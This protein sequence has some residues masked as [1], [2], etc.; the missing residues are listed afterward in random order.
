[1]KSL[2]SMNFIYF[3]VYSPSSWEMQSHTLSWR[4]MDLYSSAEADAAVDRRTERRESWK[5]RVEFLF[6]G[7]CFLGIDDSD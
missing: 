7:S 4:I 6:M 2:E 1:M 3:A 5:I